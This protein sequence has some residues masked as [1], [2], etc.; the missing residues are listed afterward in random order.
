MKPRTLGCCVVFVFL[1]VL[2][3]PKLGAQQSS[4]VDHPASPIE[5][6]PLSFEPNRGQMDN[7]VRFLA[8]TSSYTVLLES[9]KAILMLPPQNQGEKPASVAME[10]I[11][12]NRSPAERTLDRL[13]GLSNYF[14]GKHSSDWVTGIPQYA[15][16]A[17]ASVYPGIDVMYYGSKGKLEFDFVL[18]PGSDSQKI[19]LRITGTTRISTTSS[20]NLLLQLHDG[21]IELRK[22]AIYQDTGGVRRAI[23]GNFVLRPNHEI[24]IDVGNYD[25]H[26]ALTIDPALSYST[27]IGAN[28]NTTVQGVAVDGLGNIYFTGTTFATNYPTVSPFQPTNHGTTNVFVTKLNSAGNTI[29]YSTYLG[30]SGFPSAAAIAVDGGGNAYVTGIAAMSDFPTTPGAFLTTCP[31]FCNAPFVSKFRSNGTLGYSTFMG[32]SNTPVSAIAVD[33]LGEAYIAGGTASNDV[34]TTPGSFEPNYPSSICTTCVVA[35]IEKLNASG[36]NLVYSTYFALAANF[37]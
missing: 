14:L 3:M 7:K 16:V 26:Q 5:R 6:L 36:S 4:T 20:G 23:A 22:P 28:N 8:R 11:N 9:N 33:S 32:G 13:P 34:P 24:G 29:L 27:L 25:H 18:S 31:A 35:Y 17:F 10:L 2:G 1:C 37:P 15:K 30:G 19:R 12:S 21:S